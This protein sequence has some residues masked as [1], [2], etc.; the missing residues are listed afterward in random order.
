MVLQV[1]W[2]SFFRRFEFW[3][4]IFSVLHQVSTFGRRCYMTVGSHLSIYLNKHPSIFRLESETI[5][6]HL[7]ELRVCVGGGRGGGGWRWR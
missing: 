7:K 2:G 6:E 1:V 3:V 5:F 4:A